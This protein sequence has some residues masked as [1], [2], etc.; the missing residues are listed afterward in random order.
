MV[1]LTT[2]LGLTAAGALSRSLV[3]DLMAWW[4]VWLLIVILVIVLKGRRIGKVRVSGLMPLVT[5]VVLGFFVWGHAAGWS[6][7]PS[8][9]QALVG[10]GTGDV[11]T[12]VMTARIDGEIQVS[13]GAGFLYEVGPVRRGGEI[14]IPTATEE[15]QEGLVSV[16]LTQPS[17][18]GFYAFSG[19]D[20]A[21]SASVP[22]QLHLDGRVKAD[23][24]GL[25][26]SGAEFSGEGSV[27]LKAAAATTP[28][29]LDGTFVIVAPPG[30]PIRIVGDAVVPTSWEQ[31]TDGWRSPNPGEGWVVSVSEVS[32]LTVSETDQ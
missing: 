2:L 31:L 25:E 17:D 20:I 30:F 13:G 16:S 8:S 23:L 22:W 32:S 18:P 12:A 11:N 15:S 6:L 24:T 14:G 3:L 1:T 29:S 26:I 9:T 21:L 27:T 5:T 7:M 4:P 10:P 19:W 28:V